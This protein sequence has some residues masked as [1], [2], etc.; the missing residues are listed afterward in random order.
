MKT[1]IENAVQGI[2]TKEM[3]HVALEEKVD[4]EIP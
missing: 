3:R 1:Q 2:V 4:V